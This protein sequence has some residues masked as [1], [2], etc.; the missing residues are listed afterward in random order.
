MAL[1]SRIADFDPED[2]S[3]AL[4]TRAAVRM[5]VMRGTLHLVTADDARGLYPPMADV[6]RRQ[7]RSSPYAK[8]LA[9]LDLEPV[10][11]AA[12]AAVEARPMTPSDL[13][14][15]LAEAWPAHDPNALAYAARFFLP[16]VQ[17]P[18]RGLWR[19]TGR[20]TNTTAEAWLGTPLVGDPPADVVRRYL[21]AFGPATVADARAWSGLTGLREVVDA[22]RPGLRA[23]RDEGGRELLDVPDGLL[24]P[25]DA[26]APVRFLPQ[27]DN[28]FLAHADRSRIDGAM[29]WGIDF[30]WKGPILVDGGITGA[31]RIRRAR[32]TATM[33]VELGR[34]L[35]SAERADLEA[36]ADRLARFL[37]PGPRRDVVIVGA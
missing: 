35:T 18:P 37:D 28:V 21:R 4:E 9:D 22:L 31:W 29:H 34:R 5:A 27:Y 1:W 10:L 23:Y 14:A 30:G 20:P 33:T 12:R 15:S 16:L 8:R 2:L 36:E 25:E 24:A 3:R 11:R 19:R 13:G 6:M 7:W 26:P 32:G 17:V